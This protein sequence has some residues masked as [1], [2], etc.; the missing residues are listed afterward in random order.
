MI[1]IN[2]NEIKGDLLLVFSALVY[3]SGLVAQKAGMNNLGPFTF[4]AIRFLM[5]SN[6]GFD[7]L[8]YFQKEVAGRH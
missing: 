3:G 4:T 6:S 1:K 7:T 5:H 8:L 2:L